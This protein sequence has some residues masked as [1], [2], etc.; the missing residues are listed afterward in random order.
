MRGPPPPLGAGSCSRRCRRGP[1]APTCMWRMWRPQ[2]RGA[3]LPDCLPARLPACSR[4]L[5]LECDSLWCHMQ[6]IRRRCAAR[7]LS[8]WRGLP[9]RP[10][11]ASCCRRCCCCRPPPAALPGRFYAAPAVGGMRRWLWSDRCHGP[12]GSVLC[13]GSGSSRQQQWAH[14]ERLYLGT[15]LC[16]AGLVP[17]PAH[18]ST[19]T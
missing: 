10:P 4:S 1:R 3:S 13:E 14:H 17:L 16:E 11:S 8:T 18:A 19:H 9:A 7:R 6:C 15:H 2:P 12:A 5:A